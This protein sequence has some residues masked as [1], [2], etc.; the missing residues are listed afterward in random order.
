MDD[1]FSLLVVAIGF[2]ELEVLYSSS[3]THKSNISP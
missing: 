3:R 1:F 2:S